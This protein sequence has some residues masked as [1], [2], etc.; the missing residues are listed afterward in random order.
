MKITVV[1]DNKEY[2]LVPRSACADCDLH[3]IKTTV[4]RIHFL[5]SSFNGK[6]VC[7]ALNGMWKEVK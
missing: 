6:L 5:D 3:G 4:C 7:S 1:K 2:E